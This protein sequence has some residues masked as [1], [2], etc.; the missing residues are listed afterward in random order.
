MLYVYYTRIYNICIKG[1]L[2]C[3]TQ[4]QAFS[5]ILALCDASTPNSVIASK[6]KSYL[7][8][9]IL[10][11]HACDFIMIDSFYQL[12]VGQI[13]AESACMYNLHAK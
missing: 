11:Y 13:I 6:P 1:Y 7:C 2:I 4:T 9:L 8:L 10:L 12:L 3:P 5:F